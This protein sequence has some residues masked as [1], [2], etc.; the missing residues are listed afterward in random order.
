MIKYTCGNGSGNTWNQ[1]LG[2]VAQRLDLYCIYVINK[3]VTV[4]L[5]VNS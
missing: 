2:G 5:Y 3:S 1:R 4:L